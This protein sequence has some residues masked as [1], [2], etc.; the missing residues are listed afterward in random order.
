MY[1]PATSSAAAATSLALL[2]AL[3]AGTTTQ[4]RAATAEIGA[5]AEVRSAVLPAPIT[6]GGFAVQV[7]EATGSYAVPPGYSVI[8][9]WSHSAGTTAGPLTFKVYRPTG[10]LRE[11]T[12]VASDTRLVTAG[13]VQTFPVKIP[14]QPGDRIG[15]S[16]DEVQLA[17]E[18]LDTSDRIGFFSLDLPPGTTRTTDGEPFQEYKLDV[19]ATVSSD[20]D[21]P[22]GAGAEATDAYATPAP[23]LRRL[24]MVPSRFAAARSGGSTRAVRP[25]GFGTRV[26]YRSD[27]RARVRFTVQRVR[28]GRRR[29]TGRNARCVAPTRR[30]R[31]ARPC[32]RYLP[33]RGS[34]TRPA[35][36]GTNRFVFTGRVGGR[37]LARG[38][39][40]LL[41]TPTAN[42]VS[43]RTLTRRFR[44]T[45]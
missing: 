9:A 30:N 15:L 37:R 40:R 8:T 28:S 14:V 22:P 25:R 2:V 12:A 44:I 41:A 32:T 21:A 5:V 36:S 45:R 20:P 31:T 4:A 33:V 23:R 26:S 19:A 38:S 1:M 27:M 39:Y 16:A 10:A 17:F 35:R 34:F 29:G 24:S 11:F 43:G 13:T 7:A 42:G 6:E 3:L 18:T